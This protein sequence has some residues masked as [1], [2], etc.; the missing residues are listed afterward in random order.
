MR[1]FVDYTELSVAAIYEQMNKYQCKH[2]KT[3]GNLN[4]AVVNHVE[5]KGLG[6]DPIT[7]DSKIHSYHIFT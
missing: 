2:K 3:P 6:L 1:R 4:D 5:G 7:A